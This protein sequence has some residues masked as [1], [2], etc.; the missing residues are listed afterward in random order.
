MN[1]LFILKIGGKLIE[2][3]T[4]LNEALQAFASQ[5]GFKMLI[6]G[7]G[8]RASEVSQQLGI[9]VQMVNGR[10]ITDAA[11][12]EVAIMVYA[13][14]ANKTIVAKLQSLQCNAIG[15][16]GA[17]ANG[18]VAHKRPVISMDYGFVGDV[19]A[20][21]VPLIQTFLRAN[22]IPVFCAIT[23]DG[24]GQLLNTNADTIATQL[25]TALAP[26]YKVS[27]NF[28]FEKPGVLL[29]STDDN[30]IIPNLNQA[31]YQLYVKT[32]VITDGMLPKLDNAFEALKKGV[33]AVRIGDVAGIF[34]K[35]GTL[36]V[37]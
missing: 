24:N 30:A 4:L 34:T 28:C 3:E 31:D 13:G 27:L 23:H 22:L 32:G 15:L 9:P 17:D 16:S 2:D 26:F 5:S 12:L 20:V 33:K 19:D 10:R 14:L 35:A 29:N 21:N 36:L 1:K 8:K 18:I 37:E 7:G 25:A 6:H 11:T